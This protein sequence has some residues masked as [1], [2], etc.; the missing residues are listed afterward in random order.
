M[1]LIILTSGPAQ[2][3]LQFI[4]ERCT[5]D[6]YCATRLGTYLLIFLR[7]SVHRCA[8]LL[9]TIALSSRLLLLRLCL[10]ARYGPLPYRMSEVW[11]PVFPTVVCRSY[12]SA[13]VT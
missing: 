1:C 5:A 12:Y 6:F 13:I 8:T 4:L 9:T 11:R 10:C 3:Q 7:G 2:V